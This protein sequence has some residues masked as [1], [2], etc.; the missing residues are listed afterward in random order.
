M[1][2]I[3]IISVLKSVY[4]ACLDAKRS[5]NASRRPKKSE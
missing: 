5:E 2:I 3:H 1:S 4:E